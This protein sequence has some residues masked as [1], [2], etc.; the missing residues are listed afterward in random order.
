MKK[1]ILSSIL[2][3]S[4][5]WGVTNLNI[6]TAQAGYSSCQEG[7]N[8][9]SYCFKIGDRGRLVYQLIEKLRCTGYYNAGNDSYFGP[10]TQQAVIRFQRDRGLV[11]DG[12]VG[13]DTYRRLTCNN[14]VSRRPSRKIIARGWNIE[15]AQQIIVQRLEKHKWER[16]EQVH[17]I[18][19]QYK[20]PYKN[21]QALLVGTASMYREHD[22]H[23]CSP[24]LSF[25]EFEKQSTGWK[26]VGSH[27]AVLSLGYWGKPPSDIKVKTIGNNGDNIYGVMLTNSGMHSG[28]LHED[29]SILAKVGGVMR[30]VLDTDITGNNSQMGSSNRSIWDSTIAI[31]QNKG[32]KGFFNILVSSKGIRDNKSFSEKK[33]FKFNGQKYTSRK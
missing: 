30:V 11:A 19:G 22:C 1:L 8:R 23:G 12:V 29:L 32:S 24:D 9:G 6:A 18:I 25:F 7:T 31:Q 10:V 5:I 2:I 4:T 33:I 21:K 28:N 26:L 3:T 16:P 15:Q 20:L 17:T 27:I 13:P 14:K